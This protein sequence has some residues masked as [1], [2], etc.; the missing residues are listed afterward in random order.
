MQDQFHFDPA[1]VP[2]PDGVAF[3]DALGLPPG[4]GLHVEIGF[5]KDIRILREA[6][7]RPQEFFVGV[8]VSRKKVAS[9]C[10]KV[11][12]AD[13]RNVRACHGDAR[14]VLKELLPA[15]SVDSFTI[16][17]PD[18]WPKRR[19][20]KHR[21]IQADTAG[22]LRRALKRDGLLIVAT[23]HDHY[24]DQIRAVLGGSGLTAE[25]E[26]LEIPPEDKSLFAMRFERLGESVTYMRW[27]NRGSVP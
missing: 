14:K 18:P 17:F 21:W 26:S 9:F 27:R 2:L 20:W 25:Y 15:A 19:Q 24:R 5:G 4:A 3:P 6:R 23:D 16:L 1:T 12:R 11:A 7:A 10:R 13:L 8:E 22:L